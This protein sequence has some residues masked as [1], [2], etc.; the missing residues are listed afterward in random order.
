MIRIPKL[1][2]I[3]YY[4]LAVVLIY[5][6]AI[7]IPFIRIGLFMSFI[8]ILGIYL[9]HKN[10]QLKY[11]NKLDLLVG[12]YIIYNIS[13][14]VF[15][16]FAGLPI[17]VFIKEFS[18]SI[19]PIILFYFFGRVYESVFFYKITLYSLVACFIVG[20]F[21]QSTLPQNYLLFMSKIDGV[22][23]NPLN[24]VANYRSFW[25]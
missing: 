19:L 12:L 8:M 14:I 3:N 25:D 18:N 7:Y 15:F 2:I 21:L 13:T 1:T 20:F 22:S 23:A 6:I 17:I 16:M 9:L 5:F 4:Y 10:K 11:N 24:F